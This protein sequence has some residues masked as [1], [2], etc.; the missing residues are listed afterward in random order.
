MLNYEQN[1]ILEQAIILLFKLKNE[2]AIENWEVQ[3]EREFTKKNRNGLF[4]NIYEQEN[5]EVKQQPK[6]FKRT[7]KIEGRDVHLRTRL[8]GKGLTFELRYRKEGLNL[9]V[10]RKDKNAAIKEFTRKLKAALKAKEALDKQVPTGFHEFAMYYFENFRKRKVTVKTYQTDLNRYKIHIRPH[11]GTVHLGNILPI[12]CQ[13][14]IDKIISAGHERTAQDVFS[15]L[16]SIFKSAI[17]HGVIERNPLAILLSVTHEREH[18]KALTKA[19]EKHLLDA[20]AGTPYR[21]M[22]AVALYT[23]LRPNEFASARIDGKFI[24][25][26]NSKRKTK[27]VEYKK[28]P[29]TPM[30]R[31]HLEGVTELQFFRAETLRN[32]FKEILPEHKLYDLRTT[33]YTRCQE[34][35]IADVARMEFVGH[36]LGKLGNTYTDLS[37]EFLLKEG[38]KFFY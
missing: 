23:G 9:N 21:I 5:S 26:V 18:G 7:I 8:C 4:L 28:I 30:L 2:Q 32:K 16:N 14:L 38:E 22:F 25:A 10:A 36:S 24:V 37:D 17:A 12:Q 15:L 27:K 34:C 29:I 20:A 33:F 3:R 1:Q 13:A 31:P 19:E 35:G 6:T 11:F